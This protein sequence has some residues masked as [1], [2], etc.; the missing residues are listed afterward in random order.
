MAAGP[1]GPGISPNLLGE[2]QI[3]P[4]AGAA[5]ARPPGLA[6]P[7]YQSPPVRVLRGDGDGASV[8]LG[9]ASAGAVTGR[10]FEAAER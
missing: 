9:L 8:A 1:A 7:C 10:A 2:A 6:R 3:A 5:A 4:L